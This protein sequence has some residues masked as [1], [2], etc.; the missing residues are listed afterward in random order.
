MRVPLGQ[1][2]GD[3]Q[4]RSCPLQGLDLGLLVDAEHDGVLGQVAFH[5]MIAAGMTTAPWLITTLVSCLPVVVLGCGAGVA[6][7]RAGRRIDPDTLIRP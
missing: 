4:H 6:P 7:P 3:R 5:I 2:W 1:S